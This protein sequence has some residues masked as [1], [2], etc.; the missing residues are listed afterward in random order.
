MLGGLP[1]LAGPPPGAVVEVTAPM[2]EEPLVTAV[3]PRHPRQPAPAQDGAEILRGVPGFAL[4][5]KGGSGGEP[6]LRGMAGSRLGILADAEATPGGCGGRMDPPTAYVFPEDYDR[7]QVLKGAQSVLHGPGHSAGTVLFQRTPPRWSRPGWAA[8]GGWLLDGFGRSD[9]LLE[10]QGGTP[11]WYARA[12]GIRSRCG[13][14]RDGDDRTV[15]SGYE[16]W[17]AHGTLGWTPAPGAR[18]ECRATRSDGQAAYADRGMDGVAFLRSNLGLAF[19]LRELGAVLEQVEGQVYWNDA[20]HV[21]DNVTLRPPPAVPG[22][23]ARNPR[24]TA[25]SLRSALTLRTG[26]AS[27]WV[28]GLDARSDRH[29]VRRSLEPWAAPVRDQPRVEDA[30]LD[31]AGLF[32]EWTRWLSGGGRLAAGF[33][34]DLWRAG[35]LR[36]VLAA[37]GAP[38][39]NPT[40]GAVREQLL[41]SGFARWER[42]LGPAGAAVFAGLGHIQRA[43]DYWELFAPEAADGPSGFRTRAE[44]T[45]QLDF[46]ASWELGRARLDCTGFR[47]EAEDFILIQ[48]GV[49]RPGPAGAPRSATVAR[50]VRASTWGGEL[51][52]DGPWRAEGSLAWVAGENRSDGLPLG[53]MPPLEARAGLAWASGAWSAGSLVRLVAPQDRFAPG[54]G[55]I[56]GQDL[57]RTA[58]FAVCSVNAGFRPGPKGLRVSLGVDNLFDRAYAEHLNHAAIP[59]P[60]DPGPPGRIQEPGRRVWFRV[61]IEIPVQ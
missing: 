23:M 14:Y 60:G 31:S 54:Q 58:G 28:L 29:S 40:S 21:M 16:R 42:P 12:T 17:S 19:E 26:P 30:R 33:R 35:D 18:L 32:C 46:G 41:A 37:G 13:D 15:R 5:R 52:L 20:D 8:R 50:N 51:A 11:R 4:A 45:T 48:S 43:P 10:A 49:A 27:A 36:R 22:P 61:S 3:D 9:R 38:A 24:R 25:R 34:A 57:G 47:A 7:I 53:Q 56:A 1:L 2:P 44:R 59:A 6:V 39:P 55:S